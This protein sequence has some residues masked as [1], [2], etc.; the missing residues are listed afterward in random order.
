M[1]HL[2]FILLLFL[3][4]SIVASPIE[5]TNSTQHINLTKNM[6][7]IIE[8]T[9]TNPNTYSIYDVIAE[10]DIVVTSSK[11]TNLEPGENTSLSITLNTENT[12]VEE[13]IVKI[14]G[15]TRINCSE[16]G[17]TSHIINITY[18][19]AHPRDLEICRNDNVEF[20]NSYGGSVYLDIDSLDIYQGIENGNSFI[21]NYPNLGTNIIYKIEPLI[22]L[23]YITVRDEFSNIHDSNDDGHL[24][25][26]IN[27]KLEETTIESTFSKLN[28][29]IIYDEIKTNYFIIK[30]IGNKKAENINIIGEW[31]SFDNNNFDIEPGNEVAVNFVISPIITKTSD[32]GKYYN[33]TI[34]INGENTN[35]IIQEMSVYI[36]SSDIA[37]G[38]LS[39]PVWWIKRKEFCDNYPTSPDCL[40]EP[41]VI[42]RD[43]LI[44]DAPPLLLNMSPKDVK[45]YMDCKNTL[46][47]SWTSYNNQWKSDSDVIKNGISA[48]Q[49]LA[50]ES[51]ISEQQNEKTFN[52]F[53]NVF[54]IIFGTFIFIILGSMI[55]YVLYKYYLMRVSQQE[56]NI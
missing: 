32:T 13:K 47:N 14:I 54:Y 29:S 48:T 26:V 50:N 24:T 38:N 6:N 46:L 4:P 25:L 56:G 43:K 44:Y 9:I 35:E 39:S 3:I 8:I 28:F 41:Y 10:G 27:S 53:K 33:K 16:L 21:Q 37:A 15:F 31:F 12:G 5:I 42:Y 51:L 23:G 55:G 19:G 36:E 52:N 22:D 17:Q 2:L 30:N 45:E 7:K 18:G 49:R 34:Y 11:I 20:I 40:T 1:K